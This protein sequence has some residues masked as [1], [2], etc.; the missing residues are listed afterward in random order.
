MID[1]PM[2]TVP[3]VVELLSPGHRK[4]EMAH[5]ISAC[6]TLSAADVAVVSVGGKVTSYRTDGARP[7]SALGVKLAPAPE[8]FR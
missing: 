1:G 4:T 3:P 6:L 7:E 8:L 5:R 2:E